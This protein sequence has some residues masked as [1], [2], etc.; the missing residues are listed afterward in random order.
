MPRTDQHRCGKE[1][2]AS[3]GTRPFQPVCVGT[4]VALSSP[5]SGG[6]ARK[7]SEGGRLPAERS[8]DLLERQERLIK[9]LQAEVERLQ[10]RLAQ[11]EPE[12]HGQ[13]TP[14]PA[15]GPT[16]SAAYSV[17]AEER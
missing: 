6:E 8:L 17:A 5:M 16:P 7:E 11:Y 2:R 14:R 12:A 9:H 13:A 1:G 4:G 3:A 15:D 10:Q